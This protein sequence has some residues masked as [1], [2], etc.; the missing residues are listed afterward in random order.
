MRPKA[1]I[2]IIINLKKT[3]HGPIEGPCTCLFIIGCVCVTKASRHSLCTP[4]LTGSLLVAESWR[5]HRFTRQANHRGDPTPLPKQR[6]PCGLPPRTC[7][8]RM[9]QQAENK[10]RMQR[11]CPRMP[12]HGLARHG[13]GRSPFVDD[14]CKNEASRAASIPARTGQDRN[15]VLRRTG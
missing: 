10:P 2:I 1:I 7:R 13:Y 4:S 8:N 3:G 6:R 15:I 5:Q 9:G 12:G 11:L 14:Y